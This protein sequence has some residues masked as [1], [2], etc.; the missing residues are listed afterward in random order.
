MW[1]YFFFIRF[2]IVTFYIGILREVA[3]FR[4]FLRTHVKE[5]QNLFLFSHVCFIS[6][7]DN[8]K[9]I[10]KVYSNKNCVYVQ[11]YQK[12]ES[13]SPILE[14]AFP[15]TRWSVVALLNKWRLWPAAAANGVYSQCNVLALP[16]AFCCSNHFSLSSLFIV[17]CQLI[18]FYDILSD[19]QYDFF[20]QALFVAI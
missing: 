16:Y 5:R 6:F 7:K 13:K 18:L 1:R 8:H 14:Q 12:E 11:L 15:D 19:S 17:L 2:S 10:N 9:P 4:H 20:V 3:F